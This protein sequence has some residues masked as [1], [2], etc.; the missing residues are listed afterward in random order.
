MSGVE[1]DCAGRDSYALA[2]HVAP[3]ATARAVRS[4]NALCALAIPARTG[5][6]ACAIVCAASKPC[7]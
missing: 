1:G 3:S 6:A 2:W 7:A 5:R 4:L